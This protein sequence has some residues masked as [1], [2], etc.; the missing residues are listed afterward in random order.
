MEYV[1][2]KEDILEFNHII[3]EIYG[4]EDL[5]QCFDTFLKNISS[6]VYFEKGDIY[7]FKYANG[8]ITYDSYI[9]V[10]YGKELDIYKTY[11]CNLDDVL[12]LISVNQPVMFRSSDIFLSSEREKTDYYKKHLN[13]AKMHHSIEGNLYVDENGTVVGIGL[14]RS[15]SY[16]DFSQKELDILKLMRPHLSKMA[17]RFL[18][19][20][21]KNSLNERLMDF[22]LSEFKEIGIWMWNGTGQLIKASFDELNINESH[23]EELNR[24][25]SSLCVSLKN[26]MQNGSQ[27][28]PQNNQLHSKVLFEGS[29]YYAS[30][31]FKKGISEDEDRFVAILYDYINIIKHLICSMKTQYDFTDREFEVLKCLIEGMNINEICNTLFI[32][33]STVKKH[34][35]NIYKKLNIEGRHQLISC[36]LD[37]KI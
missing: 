15:D 1:F 7:I 35:T 29:T 2:T 20:S 27:E 6:L 36:M 33:T 3:D 19:S 30:I 21:D 37:N 18:H 31:S 16:D 13:P 25:L 8:K 10:G 12:P 4:S 28:E 5:P 24:I 17:E 23:H 32:S 14:H 9:S 26:N 34:M 11:F 22:D